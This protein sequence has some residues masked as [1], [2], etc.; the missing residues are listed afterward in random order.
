MSYCLQ[1]SF[2]GTLWSG[3]GSL[4]ACM[5]SLSLLSNSLWRPWT[6]TSQD[7]LSVEFFRQEYWSGL[8]FLL[9]GIFLTQGLNLFLL[10]LLHGPSGFFNLVPF[11]KPFY[12]DHYEMVES[13]PPQGDLSASFMS[14]WSVQS[15][16]AL[17][18]ERPVFGVM[19]YGPWLEN[20]NK[21]TFAFVFL[22]EIW[23][24]NGV[25]TRGFKPWL[26]C[27]LAFLGQGLS[28]PPPC[29]DQWGKAH[30]PLSL[31]THSEGPGHKSRSPSLIC[32]PGSPGHPG[33]QVAI[34]WGCPP[35]WIRV[36]GPQEGKINFPAPDLGIT[37]SV[38]TESRKFCC[39][40]KQILTSL[41]QPWWSLLP[42]LLHILAYVEIP[43][44]NRRR[45]I[46]RGTF[47]K[48]FLV[49]KET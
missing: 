4:C 41:N 27:S 10:H 49:L 28:S 19:L 45:N 40:P 14:V 33:I 5:L 43:A 13:G 31:S 8:H 47:G 39:Q 21:L 35:R 38:C 6:V 34:L 16:K 2:L 42:I 15:L 18:T 48:G 22:S 20:F 17:C 12:S 26:A 29:H 1:F 25:C 11:G 46:C 32:N 9:Q 37:L 23:W 36:V 30:T 44:N 24:N 3:F 7:P